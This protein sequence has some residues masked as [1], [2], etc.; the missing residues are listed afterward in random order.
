MKYRRKYTHTGLDRDSTTEDMEPT[1][2]FP[3]VIELNVGGT[4]YTTK[5]STLRKDPRS[6][7]AT[8]FS[9]RHVIERT[10]D[11]RFFID[12]EGNSFKY[13]LQYLRDGKMP[14][15][16]EAAEVYEEACYY[17]ISGLLE[18][19]GEFESTRRL[20]KQTELRKTVRDKLGKDYNDFLRRFLSR[21]E[22]SR[23]EYLQ[24]SF[25][26]RQ[27]EHGTLNHKF[28][29]LVLGTDQGKCTSCS[30][31]VRIPT[32]SRHMFERL[33]TVTGKG[34][35]CVTCVPDLCIPSSL[36]AVI[37]ER[38]LVQDLRRTGE[39]V[40]SECVIW[41]CSQ[42][43]HSCYSDA[44]FLQFASGIQ[45]FIFTVSALCGILSK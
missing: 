10:D 37:V 16:T 1:Q 13:I 36:P 5:L 9:G 20:R 3:S 30:T 6:M 34:V 44:C 33:P 43:L 19:L 29:I 27:D 38:F 12:R 7:L 31:F 22:Q 28:E 42:P 32:S 24:M 17:Q 41:E 14:P 11:G 45:T 4:L 35:K 26:R 25:D 23:S 8:M 15:A 18:A 21:I 39:E 2:K 40:E